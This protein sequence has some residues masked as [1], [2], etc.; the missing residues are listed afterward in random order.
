MTEITLN[1]SSKGQ[2]TLPKAARERLGVEPGGR[3]LLNFGKDPKVVIKKSPTIE[4]YY[5][6]FPDLWDG[7]DPVKIIREL[8]DNDRL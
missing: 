7:Q 3:V 4:D 6:K 2:I 8:R 5:G 1:V